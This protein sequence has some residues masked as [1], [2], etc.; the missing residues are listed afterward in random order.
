MDGK[1]SRPLAAAEG[2]NRTYNK[3]ALYIGN[4][5]AIKLCIAM[6]TG[7]WIKLQYCGFTF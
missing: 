4:K 6:I 5:F 3:T 7:G 2:R 1:L